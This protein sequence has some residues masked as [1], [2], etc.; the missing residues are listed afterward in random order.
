LFENAASSPEKHL[1]FLLRLSEAE[2]SGKQD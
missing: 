1:E 2:V